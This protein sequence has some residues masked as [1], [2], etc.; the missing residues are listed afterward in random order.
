MGRLGRVAL[1]VAGLVVA[2]VVAGIP[3]Y[4]VP[5]SDDPDEVDV[6]VAY[7]IG[8]PTNG[9]MEIATEMVNEGRADAILVSLDPG[10][11]DYYEAAA[12]LCAG[13]TADVL[14]VDATILCDKPDPFTTRGEARWL[15]DEMAE[16]SWDSAAVIT[17]TPHVSR[18]RMIMERCNTRDVAMVDSGGDLATSYW[19]YQYA[20]QTAAFAKAAVLQGC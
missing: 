13:D 10:A 18:T 16:H 3:L 5:A 20:Y 14:A 6:D 12:H 4:V 11:A 9:R 19:A 15:E 1:G 17:F 7:V 8:P 2:V